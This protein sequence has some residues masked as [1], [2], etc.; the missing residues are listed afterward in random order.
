MMCMVGY[1]RCGGLC[2]VPDVPE[3]WYVMMC[4]RCGMW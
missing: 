1:V 3:V 4:L 2:D